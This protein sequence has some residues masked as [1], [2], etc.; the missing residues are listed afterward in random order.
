[1]QIIPQYAIL[2]ETVELLYKFVNNQTLDNV[3]R[4]FIL[5]HEAHLSE[6]TRAH[7]D[8]VISALETILSEGTRGL[9]RN[10][11]RLQYFFRSLQ[12]DSGRDWACLA[13]ILLCSFYDRETFGFEESI[14]ECRRNHAKTAQLGWEK[15]RLLDIDRAGMSFVPIG[16]N[17]EKL[18]LFRQL[19][20]CEIPG[21][22]KW[23]IYK[24]ML[25]YDAAVTELTEL[26]RPVAQRL[27]TIL[28]RFDDLAQQTVQLWQAYFAE[29]SYAE[30]K[31]T[32]MGV[33]SEQAPEAPKQVLCFWWLGCNQMH[34]YQDGQL[35]VINAGMLICPGVSPKSSRFAQEYLVNILKFLSDN[36]KFEI[37]RRLSER[38]YYGLELANEMQLTSGTISKHLNT[39]FSYGLIN[40][41]RV[42]N[43]VYYQTDEAAVRRVVKQIEDGLLGTGEQ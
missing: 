39:L 17:E 15:F 20:N 35:E 23:T 14:A 10:D 19:D 27:E 41:R 7:Y 24:A 6:A 25:E 29:H 2:L 38:S 28:R 34:Y 33:T 31:R 22:C 32:M 18:S 36:S 9:D 16:E 11:L 5:R 13:Q 1:M 42:N 4:N 37:I 12:P 30:C 43:R 8:A 21:S 3:R 40:L 26:L